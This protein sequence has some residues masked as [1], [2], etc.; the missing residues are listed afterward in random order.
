MSKDPRK[1]TKAAL[2][3]ICGIH[4]RTLNRLLE[5]AEPLTI[6]K[7]QYFATSQVIGALRTDGIRE[8][9]AAKTRL[10]RAHADHEEI[11]VRDKERE[12]I[13]ADVV[14]E[15][16]NE[17]VKTARAGLLKLPKEIARAVWG[18]KDR[19]EIEERSREV[20]CAALN[21]LANS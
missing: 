9:E 6:G 20:V 8:S 10:L 19:R 12:L 3:V 13:P 18:L 4:V 16:W 14:A 11:K 2:S 7:R 21:D 15:S 1:H 17:H 5:N